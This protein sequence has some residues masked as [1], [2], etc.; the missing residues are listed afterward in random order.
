MALTDIPIFSMLRTRLEW[1]QAR[2]RVL[3]ENVANADTPNF[4]PRDLAPPKFDSASQVRRRRCSSPRPKA[5]IMPGF[6]SAGE[7]FRS[8][9]AGRLRRAARRQ[10]GQSRGRDDEGRRQP[11]GL[12][13]G[14]ALYTRS[15]NLLK[16]AIGK[17]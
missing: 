5:G 6:G 17:A 12:P 8:E 15:L 7:P 9:R 10:R 14:D 13:G 11:D 2:Q 4:R 16:T 3:A 1:A